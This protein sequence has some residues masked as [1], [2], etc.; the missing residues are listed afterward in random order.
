MVLGVKPTPNLPGSTQHLVLFDFPPILCYSFAMSESDQSTAKNV[1]LDVCALCR[2]FDDQQQVRI[3]LETSAVELI[4]AHV[5]QTDLTSDLD[6][7]Y[8]KMMAMT[9]NGGAEFVGWVGHAGINR[10]VR[11]ISKH[12]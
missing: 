8:A 7:V 9:T 5:R 10:I 4:L 1:Y 6:T 12:F 2:P 3:R 11:H